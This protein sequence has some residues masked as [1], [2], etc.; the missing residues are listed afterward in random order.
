MSKLQNYFPTSAIRSL[1]RTNYELVGDKMFSE[2]EKLLH[3]RITE[4]KSAD[5]KSRLTSENYHS[6][7]K[8]MLQ[9]EDEIESAKC[10]SFDQE[11]QKVDHVRERIYSLKVVSPS[12][13]C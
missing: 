8:L 7:M 9:M 2:E 6:M 5:N 13:W 11:N 4:F 12:I 1:Q 3:Q 10:M